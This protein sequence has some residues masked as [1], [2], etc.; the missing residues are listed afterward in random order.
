MKSQA[1]FKRK[2]T[3][4]ARPDLAA[5]WAAGDEGGADAPAPLAVRIADGPMGA[6][7]GARDGMSP[8]GGRHE[9]RRAP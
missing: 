6:V 7:Q 4:E 2:M 3:D 8:S 1:P 9:G 5:P